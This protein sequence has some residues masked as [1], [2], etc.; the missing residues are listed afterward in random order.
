MSINEKIY[1]KWGF[2]GGV[3]FAVLN[4]L[5]LYFVTYFSIRTYVLNLDSVFVNIILLNIFLVFVYPFVLYFI[6]K[7]VDSVLTNMNKFY[8][9]IFVLAGILVANSI[10]DSVLTKS[11]VF[12]GI[13]LIPAI[14]TFLVPIFYKTKK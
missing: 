9:A 4:K 7:K 1:L 10:I 8:V 5:F 12:E 14:I 2:L 3:I 11:F 13:G 6:I